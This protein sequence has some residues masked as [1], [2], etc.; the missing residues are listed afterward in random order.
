MDRFVTVKRAASVGQAHQP[1]DILMLIKQVCV[2]SQMYSCKTD[3]PKT[4][5]NANDKQLT[6]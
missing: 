5:C 3:Y 4:W 6:K 2:K 1:S